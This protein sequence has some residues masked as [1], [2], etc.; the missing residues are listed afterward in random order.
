MTTGPGGL[1]SAQTTTSNFETEFS[2][3]VSKFEISSIPG[4]WNKF[5]FMKWESN[6]MQRNFHLQLVHCTK[7]ISFI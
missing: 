3:K 2:S 5:S 7:Q 1:G 4:C 6:F